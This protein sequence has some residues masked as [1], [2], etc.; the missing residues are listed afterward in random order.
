MTA[1]RVLSM[2]VRQLTSMSTCHH[3]PFWRVAYLITLT[4]LTS[5]GMFVLGMF[6]NLTAAALEIRSRTRIQ[7]R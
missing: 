6:V 4:N 5:T 7:N 1:E 2:C 3:L